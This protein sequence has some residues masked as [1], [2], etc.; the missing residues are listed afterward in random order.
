MARTGQDGGVEPRSTESDTGLHTGVITPLSIIMV[1]GTIMVII[2][3]EAAIMDRRGHLEM[4]AH[5][6]QRADTEIHGPAGHQTT[7]Q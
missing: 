1:D 4:F 6:E 3:T 7:C 5:Q 2:L